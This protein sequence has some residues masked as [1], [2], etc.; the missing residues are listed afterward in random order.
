[1]RTRILVPILWLLL[2]AAI[3]LYVWP[4][5]WRYDHMTV[6]NDTYPVRID[7]ITGDSDV[8]LPGDGWTPTEEALQDSDGTDQPQK[9][10]RIAVAEQGQV[11][12]GQNCI[13]SG[14]ERLGVCAHH[15]SH[16]AARRE[17]NFDRGKA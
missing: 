17:R 8:L 9:K 12:C 6:D 3:A 16:G 13:R 2:A 4:T 15:G 11:R 1:M 5:R 7:R 14:G 10:R